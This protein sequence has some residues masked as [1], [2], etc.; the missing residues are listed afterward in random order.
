MLLKYDQIFAVS[1]FTN[2]TI[3]QLGY[4]KDNRSIVLNNCLDPFL[5]KEKNNTK[6]NELLFRYGLTK[7]NFVLLTLS[8]LSSDEKYKGYDKVLNCLQSLIIEYP[9][10]RYLIIG[11]YDD[12]EKERMD[13][14]IDSM[15]LNHAVIFS[16]Y[17]PDEELSSHYN[18][19]DLY[20]MPSLGEG[21]GIVFIEAMYYGLPVIA[22]NKDG[23]VDALLNG[24]LGLLIN[25]DEPEEITLAIKKVIDNKSAFKPDYNLL[26]QNFSYKVYKEKMEWA[27]KNLMN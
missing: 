26:M 7:E 20:I 23:S 12:E 22:G 1:N 11:K 21:F 25:P 24:K 6:S 5:Q 2:D 27:L 17:I 9:D 4:V 18:L 8:R 3:K 19:A 16:G 10:L 15:N 14:M 13:K